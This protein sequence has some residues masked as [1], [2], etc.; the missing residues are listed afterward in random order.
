MKEVSSLFYG[1]LTIPSIK[2]SPNFYSPISVLKPQAAGLCFKGNIVLIIIAFIL[3]RV[4]T[5]FK[6]ITNLWPRPQL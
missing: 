5:S 3:K 2:L 1:K 4:S 6:I